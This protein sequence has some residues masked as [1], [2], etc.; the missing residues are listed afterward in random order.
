MACILAHFT[1]LIFALGVVCL[2]WQV[3]PQHIATKEHQRHQTSMKAGPPTRLN[4]NINNSTDIDMM[5]TKQ[6]PVTT[7]KPSSSSPRNQEKEEQPKTKDVDAQVATET[8]DAEA[9]A[10]SKS[11]DDDKKLEEPADDKSTA[12]PEMT[13]ERTKTLTATGDIDTRRKSARIQQQASVLLNDLMM[14]QLKLSKPDP[15]LEK[16]KTKLKSTQ[17]DAI[18]QP[19]VETEEEEEGRRRRKKNKKPKRAKTQR[20]RSRSKSKSKS[21]SRSSSA[22]KV[23]YSLCVCVTVCVIW[24]VDVYAGLCA[25]LV[26]SGDMHITFSPNFSLPCV[27]MAKRPRSLSA[28]FFC[29]FFVFST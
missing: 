27:R 29:F 8:V 2:V 17:D 5:N 22:R 15:W 16:L 3:V 18:D 23:S 13:V 19:T 25:I 11:G 6:S 7:D 28:V 21:R 26:L 1:F 12:E 10:N 9:A 24:N 14:T 20:S 4:N